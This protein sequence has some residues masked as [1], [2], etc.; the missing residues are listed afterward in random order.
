MAQTHGVMSNPLCFQHTSG[1]ARN[2]AVTIGGNSLNKNPTEKLDKDPTKVDFKI[3]TGNLA[4]DHN[5]VLV[6]T[7]AGKPAKGLTK[8]LAKTK[9]PGARNEAGT[10]GSNSLI[11]N[12][13]EKFDK[14]PAKV[15]AKTH[16]RNI[17]KDLNRKFVKTLAGKPAKGLAKNHTGKAAKDPGKRLA[18]TH[19]RRLAK[20]FDK[21]SPGSTPARGT[22]RPT[23]KGSPICSTRTRPEGEL[24]RRGDQMIVQMF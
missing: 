16:T 21:A 19:T 7:L 11:K 3:L 12:L 14:D 23:P 13:N 24:H 6:K 1:G 8:G 17:A 9:E 15:D 4:K 20:M 18:K 2:E 5:R 22:P 10:N